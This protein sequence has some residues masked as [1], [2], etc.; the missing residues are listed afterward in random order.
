MPDFN[1]SKRYEEFKT[2]PFGPA[3]PRKIDAHTEICTFWPVLPR[4]APPFRMPFHT[5]PHASGRSELKPEKSLVT[6]LLFLA[7][8]V[9]S[10]NDQK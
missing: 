1:L 6:F 9:T 5:L 7:I 4:F 8:L 3:I 10:I 2:Y